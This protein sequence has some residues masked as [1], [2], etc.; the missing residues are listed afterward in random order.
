MYF[1]ALEAGVA[2]LAIMIAIEMRRQRRSWRAVLIS[3]LAVFV[4]LTAMVVM[5]RAH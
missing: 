1:M 3:S 5:W 2:A 4:T